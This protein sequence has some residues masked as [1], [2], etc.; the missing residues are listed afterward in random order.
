MVRLVDENGKGVR[1]E[2][3]LYSNN[4][5]NYLSHIKSL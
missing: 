1:M 4:Y 3:D 5:Y 2:E